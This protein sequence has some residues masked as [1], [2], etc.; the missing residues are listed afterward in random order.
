MSTKS[1]VCEFCSN[2]YT[3]LSALNYHKK[4]AKFCIELRK[5]HKPN[6]IIC[7]ECD[8]TFTT[9]QNLQNH[10][11]ICKEKKKKED[12]TKE[13]TITSYKSEIDQYKAE[14]NLYKTRINEH[15]AEVDTYKAEEFRL[16]QRI[17]DLEKEI[18]QYRQTQTCEKKITPT[19]HII[20]ENNMN[21]ITLQ[22]GNLDSV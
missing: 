14:I 19:I 4:T 13:E 10:Q 8:K 3:S 18:E 6:L 15:K 9:K 22:L 7:A 11:L 1:Y 5:N 12:E 2:S 17:T 20:A 21:R 16:Q